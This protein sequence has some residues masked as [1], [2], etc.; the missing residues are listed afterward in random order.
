M[1]RVDA[2][3][4]APGDDRTPRLRHA[5]EADRDLLFRIYAGTREEELVLADWSPEEKVAF[6]R[7]QFE[8][9][10]RYYRENY[11]AARFSI[12]ERGG[13]PVGRLYRHDR[14]DEIR[15]MDIALLPAARGEGIG[16]RLLRELM[17]E[18]EASGRSLT[19]HV[20]RFNR[21]LGL[22]RRLGFRIAEDKGVYLFLE[23][24]PDSREPG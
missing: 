2:G 19:V 24:R 4:A 10:D 22:Y 3:P 17:K 5:T 16:S 1:T 23:W 7:Q 9:Q 6:L 8:A 18:A 15:L 14:A 13:E 12:V 21:A 11:P 20:E